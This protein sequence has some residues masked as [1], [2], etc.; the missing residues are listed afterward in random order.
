MTNGST[1]Y[2][3][4]TAVNQVG[5]SV[6]S[7]AVS[8][9]AGDTPGALGSLTAITQSD[10]SVQLTW[11]PATA[12]GYAVTGYKVEQ[13]LDGV[14]FTDVRGLQFVPSIDV[15]YRDWSNRFN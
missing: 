15:I 12:N 14:A 7:S 11:T 6:F 3:K 13:S 1:Y 8:I 5:N 9:I 2:Y 4:V 10:T